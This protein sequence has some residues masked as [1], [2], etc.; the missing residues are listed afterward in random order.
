MRKTTKKTMSSILAWSTLFRNRFFMGQVKFLLVV[1]CLLIFVDL[2]KLGIFFS[3]KEFLLQM[4]DVS[5]LSC[6]L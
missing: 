3:F 5:F 1:V 4:K 6:N 2:R